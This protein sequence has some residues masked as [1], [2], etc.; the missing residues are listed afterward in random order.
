[1]RD[2]RAVAAEWRQGDDNYQLR[3]AE[4][5][6]V[7]ERAQLT[8]AAQADALRKWFREDREV[9]QKE[10]QRVADREAG[11]GQR[12]KSM[13]APLSL[14]SRMRNGTLEIYWQ[15]VHKN[16]VTGKPG[17]KYVRKAKG[18]QGNYTDRELLGAAKEFEK[19]L[20]MLAEER[21]RKLRA[22]WRH[23]V[24]LRYNL[25]AAERT[26]KAGLEL[27][28]TALAERGSIPA[29]PAGVAGLHELVPSMA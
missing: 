15:L 12:P 27:L 16:P 17:Y 4:I 3:M 19:D 29:Q 8:L 13:Y 18:A 11:V 20:V 2:L 24:L 23:C 28:E 9:L 5:E 6:A 7:L 25:Q 1:M 10:A 14:F 26:S 22:E 21:A